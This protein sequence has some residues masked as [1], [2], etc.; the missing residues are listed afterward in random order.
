MAIYDLFVSYS[1]KDRVWAE[2]LHTDLF[3]FSRSLRIFYDR[4]TIPAGSEWR[5]ELTNAIRNS[6][7]LLVFW[8]ENA[9][10]PN[11]SGVKEVDPEIAAFLAHRDLVPE[12]EGSERKVFYVPLEGERGGGIANYQG[13]PGFKDHYKPNAADLGLSNLAADPGLKEWKRMIK[14]VGD[15]ISEADSA[16]PLIAA[17]IATN[18]EA[19]P[20][21]E[22]D[23]GKRKRNNP[24][25]DEFLQGFG[26][27]WADVKNRYGRDA[28]DW[29]PLGDQ[30][31]VTLLEQVRVKLN[32]ELSPVDRFQWKYIDLTID[33]SGE[34]RKNLQRVLDEPS[35][36]IFDPISLYDWNCGDALRDLEDY[37]RQPQAVV[38]SLSPVVQSSEDLSARYLRAFSKPIL[39]DY[40]QPKIPPEGAFAARCALDVRKTSQ[41]E[42]LVRNRIRY[43]HLV[44][45]TAEA[46]ATTGQG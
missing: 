42:P 12:L 1:S 39:D 4:E 6:K 17:V 25:L 33:E 45:K 31:I 5:R 2:K 46:K 15:A 30:T 29:C 23:R 34:Y 10:T 27:T 26:I 18:S 38:I 41:I 40:F 19:V 44:R 11:T 32:V 35:V 24:T 3:T 14:M 28:L 8:S 22:D 9:D 20:E 16:Q 43:R 21:L 36:V 7:H 37:V 13:F